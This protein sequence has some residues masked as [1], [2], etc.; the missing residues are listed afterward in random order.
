MDNN[1]FGK[2]T[3]QTIWLKHF[4]NSIQPIAYNSIKN[5]KF[6]KNKYLPIYVNVGRNITNG[7]CYTIDK[8][9]DDFKGKTFLIYDVPEYFDIDIKTK[10]GLKVKKIRQFKGAS[11]QFEKFETFDDYF[12]FKFKSNSRYKHK[13]NIARFESC[14]DSDYKVFCGN[15]SK[16]E[17][18]IVF[19]YLKDIIRRRFETLGI[20]NNILSKSDYYE[21]LVYEMVLKK[22]A[23]LIA[24]YDGNSP[25]GVSLGFL[26]DSIMFYAI[27]SFNIDYYRFNLGHITI[28]KLMQWCFENGFKTFDFSKGLVDY[29][30]RWTNYVYNYEC[31]I[32]YDSKSF[33]SKVTTALVSR[34]LKFK[35]YLRENKINR[36]YNKI[37]FILKNQVSKIP[38]S[39]LKAVDIGDKNIDMNSLTEIDIYSEKYN[40]LK[41]P[42]FDFLYRKPEKTHEIKIYQSIDKK[43][44]Y[45]A[46]G[47]VSKIRLSY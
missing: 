6:Y 34:F 7:M 45:Y 24:I 26:S 35:Q 16:E 39:T 8:R 21:E 47:K 1:P 14:F 5:I 4:K 43:N 13:R 11:A 22:E 44:L 12:K 15:I 29:K 25:I 30:D 33:K 37:K 10:N 40:F 31:H 46:I 9:E 42:L 38:I 23:V 41:A 18:G 32:L 27:T 36:L 20:D 17:Y 19:Q 28:I 3:F 2:H